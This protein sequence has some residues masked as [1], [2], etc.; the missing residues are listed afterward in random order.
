VIEIVPAT[1]EH[2]HAIELR[3]G[4]AR[5]I[6]AMGLDKIAAVEQG[7]ARALWAETYLVDGDVAAIVGVS[8]ETLLGGTRSIWMLTGKPV[9][10]CRKAFLRATRANVLNILSVYGTVTC[11]VPMRRPLCSATDGFSG[12]A[13]PCRRAAQ[14]PAHWAGDRRRD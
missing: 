3:E 4:D 11:N 14:R 5:E 8:C 2:A 13:V 10:R 12:R 1:I 6:A 9:D 7:L